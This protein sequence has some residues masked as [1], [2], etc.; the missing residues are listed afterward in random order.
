MFIYKKYPKAFIL[1]LSITL[2]SFVMGCSKTDSE[3]LAPQEST[4]IRLSEQ[5]S[6]VSPTNSSLLNP[7]TTFLDFEQSVG[8]WYE[9]SLGYSWSAFLHGQAKRVGKSA[10]RFELRRNDSKYGHRTELGEKPGVRKE[11][12]VGFSNF[13]PS[14]YLKDPVQEAVMQFQAHPDVNKGEAWRSPPV[15]L[16]IL[17]D[18][19]IL[20]LRTDARAVTTGELKLTRIDLGPVDKEVWNDW[21]FHVK[22]AWDNTGILEVWK[23]NKLVVS[24][25]N[26][27]NSYN[28]QLDPYFKVGIYKWEWAWKS[29]PSVQKRVYFL[30]E[31]TIG[32]AAAG[33]N[34]VYPGRKR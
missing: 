12:W 32:T 9:R 27:P 29:S 20:D 11:V 13:F 2:S 10:L 15:A 26:M 31:L 30:D 25:K 4:G 8:T 16:I 17:N 28:D 6:A 5:I 34:G 19:F 7:I 18:R 33:Y 24:R 3:E 1:V 14:S 23:N 22:W 21:V